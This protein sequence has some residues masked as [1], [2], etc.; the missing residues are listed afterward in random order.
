M[1]ICIIDDEHLALEYLDFL[2]NKMEEVQ[3]T[4]KYS[5][6][7]DLINHVQRESIDAVFMDIHMPD[8]KGIDLAEKLLNIQPSLQIVF[9]TAYNEYA[10]KAFELNAL[11]YILKPVQKERLEVT[12]QRIKENSYINTN[13]EQESV[14]TKYKIKN[15]GAFRFYMDNN[16]VEVKWR[17]TKAKELF[18]YFVQNHE[19][20]IRKGELTDL[21]WSNLPWERAH[22]QLY[23]TVYQIR[24][25]T[26]QIGMPIK[27]SSQDEFYHITIDGVEIQSVEWKSAALDLLRE[28][29][30]S[31]SAYF[32]LLEAYQGDYLEEIE[33]AWVLKERNS[34]RKIWLELIDN[35]IK[36]I[37]YYE[38]PSSYNASKLSALVSSDDEAAILL[39]KKL[40]H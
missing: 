29:N 24:K 21:M 9:V 16:Q 32:K 13:T 26:Q 1:N 4:G 2:F 7:G 15:L 35:L 12:I 18:A 30:V 20:T 23:S 37:I 31:V 40:Q 28:D 10:V 17:T 5:D 34:L 14:K 33:A 27:I 11:D 3:V 8:I 6:P 39:N 38:K 25:M 22:S 19:N 36:H